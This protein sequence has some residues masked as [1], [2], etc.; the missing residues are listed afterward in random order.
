MLASPAH[1]ALALGV[2]TSAAPAAAMSPSEPAQGQTEADVAL[3][4]EDAGDAGD[5]VIVPDVSARQ[6]VAREYGPFFEPEPP[7]DTAFP[8]GPRR[9]AP[10]RFS[11][12]GGAFCFVEDANCRAAL[13]A[14]AEVAAGMNLISGGRGTDM[15][16]NFFGVRGGLTI[17]PVSLLRSRWHPW[18]V[19]LIGGWHRNTGTVAVGGSSDGSGVVDTIQ[20][21]GVR[22]G[23]VNQLWLSQKRNALHLDFTLGAVR[24]RVLNS[25]S[26]FFGTHAELAL[27]FGGWGS[28]FIAGDFLD[29]DQRLSLGLRGHALAAAPVVALILLGMLA[30]GAM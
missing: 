21:D 30:G 16:M 28:V 14:S 11:L 3:P 4:A 22:F 2:L 25:Q 20:N 29:Q 19:G 8:S 12:G 15:P 6:P 1:L 23:V 13:L 24:S 26:R 5:A 7:S 10:P 18:A 27:G 17:R 9:G